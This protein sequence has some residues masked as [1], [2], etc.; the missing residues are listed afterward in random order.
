MNATRWSIGLVLS[1][2][3]SLVSGRQLANDASTFYCVGRTEPG[4]RERGC[5]TQ[6]EYTL[7]I[8]RPTSVREVERAGA[9]LCTVNGACSL[10]AGAGLAG[11]LFLRRNRLPPVEPG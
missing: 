7:G 3:S 10:L 6:L 1:G 11:W 5:Y 8:Q 4:G 2:V 9:M